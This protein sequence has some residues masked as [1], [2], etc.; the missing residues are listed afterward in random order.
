MCGDAMRVPTDISLSSYIRDLIERD[1]IEVFYQ[2]QEWK[3]L[4]REVL[5][6]HHYECQDCLLLGRYTRADCV[7]HVNEVR[8]RPDLALSKHYSDKDGQK[9]EN[10]RPLCNTCHNIVHEKLIKH[11]QKGKF[12][13]EERW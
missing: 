12:Q 13:N 4:R 2:T 5:E 1:R 6:D 11:Q 7:H 3:D 10:L 9:K 8:V